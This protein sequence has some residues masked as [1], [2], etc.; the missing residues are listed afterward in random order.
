MDPVFLTAYRHPRESGGPGAVVAPLPLLD[1]RFRGNDEVV[2]ELF[3]IFGFI[4]VQAL[5]GLSRHTDRRLGACL[6]FFCRNRWSKSRIEVRDGPGTR[7][8]PG[9]MAGCGGRAALRSGR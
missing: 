1:S 3:E 7:K 4:F 2:R 6:F 9:P 5:G 8:A